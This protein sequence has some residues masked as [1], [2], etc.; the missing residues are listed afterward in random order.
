MQ[1]GTYP[2]RNFARLSLTVSS[3]AG[4]YLGRSSVH[5]R[6]DDAD[7]I[8]AFAGQMTSRFDDL[9][10]TTEFEEVLPLS[11]LQRVLLEEWNDSLG[12]VLDSSHAV[13]H[14]ITMVPS[15][16]ATTEVRL[17]RVKNVNVSFVL[18]DGEFWKYLMACAHLGMLVYPDMKAALTV[19]EP[20]DPLCFEIHR[21]APNVKSL[22][23]LAFMR[24]FPA[25]CPLVRRIFT[26]GDIAGEYRAAVEEFPAYGS[27]L[28]RLRD[29]QP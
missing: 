19:H 14:P 6:R 18:N 15:N 8:D 26:A 5:R 4:L 11:R 28:L 23:V 13:R 24:A 2:T 20:N 12:E 10:D 9:Q 21:S 1:V 29:I 27:V 16:H 25:D 22:R 3:E 7:V 17:E